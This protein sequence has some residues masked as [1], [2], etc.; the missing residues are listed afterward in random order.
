MK[1]RHLVINNFRGVKFL[2]WV[3]SGNYF[4]LIGPGDSTKTTILD[5]V[6]YLFSPRWNL[7]FNDLDFYNGITSEPLNVTA[8]ITELPKQLIREDKFGLFINFWNFIDGDHADEKEGDE[9]SL[10]ITLTVKADLEPEWTVVS[11]QTNEQKSISSRDREL[12]GGKQIGSYIERDFSWGRNSALTRLTGRDKID[13]IPSILAEASR[14]AREALQKTDFSYLTTSAKDLETSAK[15][16]GVT[17]KFG[18]QPGMDPLSFNIN[19]GGITLLDG[20][21][22]LRSGGLGS[23]R[24]LVMAIHKENTKEGAFILVDEIENGLEPFRLRNLIQTLRP[25]KDDSF[26][27]FVT[28]HSEISI[29]E[30]NADE[31]WVVRNSNGITTIKQVEGTL[32]AI[33]RKI[34]EALLARKIIVCE[35]KTEWGLCRA[36]D[37]HWQSL[38]NLP[39]AYFG[40]EPIC[41][42]T[43]GGTEAPK[44]AVEL[45]K[46]G[47]LV[48]YFGDSDADL[49]PSKIEME[50]LGIKVIL[51]SGGANIEMRLSLDLP[52]NALDEMI[53]LATQLIENEEDVW[54][55]IRMAV[56]WKHEDFP[57]DIYELATRLGEEIL[58]QG[59]GV[60]ANKGK[61]FKR[62]DRGEELGKLICKYL[63]NISEKDLGIK[64]VELTAWAYDRSI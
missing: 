19:T 42:S 41:S 24:L 58:R 62:P 23:R 17:P 20:M 38:G 59:V 5:A 35:G 53:K 43:S 29:V 3:L 57:R 30:C 37:D 49:N 16:L 11:L 2:D 14:N 4:C 44:Y 7:P 61:W 6:E 21:I 64:I 26:Q 46:L 32:Q 10:I 34:P 28:T 18:F 48:S 8:T 54:E 52:L 27:T 13:E 55:K 39:F 22:P 45:A 1:L 40:V 36:I 15:S 50:D 31:L 60:A 47:Y 25:K 63:G 33:V 9:Y 12:I 56:N 51:W